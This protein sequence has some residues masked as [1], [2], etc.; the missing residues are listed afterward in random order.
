MK[1]H[2][3]RAELFQAD[4]RR[5]R[6]MGSQTGGRMD[7]QAERHGKANNRFLQFCQCA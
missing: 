7:G 3:V 5:D 2:P 4:G 6:R 1:I